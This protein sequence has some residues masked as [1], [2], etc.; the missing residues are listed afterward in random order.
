MLHDNRI[1][2]IVETELSH[3]SFMRAVTAKTQQATLPSLI[4][5]LPADLLDE[6]DDGVSHFGVAYLRERFGQF[7]AVG[8]AR[9]SET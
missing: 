4:M 7:Q 3:V 2:G 5:V 6:S 9:N 1:V 8:V